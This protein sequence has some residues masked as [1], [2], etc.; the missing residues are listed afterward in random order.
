MLRSLN[1]W[2][3]MKERLER[4]QEL[5]AELRSICFGEMYGIADFTKGN[6]ALEK[7]MN[8]LSD[9]AS[10]YDEVK[11]RIEE[12]KFELGMEPECNIPD[13]G[14][15]LLCPHCKGEGEYI[16]THPERYGLK[17]CECQRVK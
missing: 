6:E 17:T 4:L 8:L 10:L 7:Q 15:M 3:I 16:D 9:E 1:R 5:T 11:E 13:V 2:I 12:K 14:R